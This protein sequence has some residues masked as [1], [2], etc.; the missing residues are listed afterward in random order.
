MPILPDID[1][2]R[3]WRGFMR[4]ASRQWDL[5][6]LTKAQLRAAVDA[7]DTWIDAN[8]GSYNAALPQPARN[9]LTAAQK[10]LLFCTV[11]A[12]RVS[13]KFAESVIGEVD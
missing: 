4:Y 13:K 5:I 1:L 2:E 8:Q 7:T 11:A 3:I 10:T 12:M 6:D 9:N